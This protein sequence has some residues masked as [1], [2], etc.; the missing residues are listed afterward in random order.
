MTYPTLLR[1]PLDDDLIFICMY[2]QQKSLGFIK[3]QSL[4]D[5]DL[6][7]ITSRVD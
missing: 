4:V 1:I 3:L 5:L 2:P 6:D 7:D